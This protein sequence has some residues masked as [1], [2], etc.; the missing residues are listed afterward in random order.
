MP[1]L[2]AGPMSNYQRQV[3]FRQRNPGYY[4]RLHR[5]R[6]AEA[7]ALGVA[8]EMAKAA[9]MAPALRAAMPAPKP[10]LMLPAPIE[11]P[12]IAEINALKARLAA[13]EKLVV[14]IRRSSAA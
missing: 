13:V 4:G 7:Q 8:M 9:A 10:V 3:A 5:R 11:D 6:R 12:A 1:I 2:R 14:P